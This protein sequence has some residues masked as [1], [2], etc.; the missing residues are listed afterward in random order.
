MTSNFSF[1][2]KK[3]EVIHNNVNIT[4]NDALFNLTTAET[5]L[6]NG[7]VPWKGPRE[8]AHLFMQFIE[9]LTK[10]GD[11]VLDWKAGTCNHSLN[12]FE[13]PFLSFSQQSLTSLRCFE[14][15]GYH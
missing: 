15:M 9:Q 12:S 6:M 13:F 3:S 11:I 1:Q 2:T 10:L 8:K 7:N 5:Q 4:K 14:L